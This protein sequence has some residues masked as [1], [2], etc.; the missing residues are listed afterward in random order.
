MC[1]KWS[2]LANPLFP[3][4]T[5]HHYD[6]H[7]LR[8]SIMSRSLY[9]RQLT[10]TLLRYGN[11]MDLSLT[12]LTSP[13]SHLAAFASKSKSKRKETGNLYSYELCFWSMYY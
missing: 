5:Y 11:S 3:A 1:A 4:S 8:N 12:S 7:L 13:A 2:T 9:N 6:V 10:G